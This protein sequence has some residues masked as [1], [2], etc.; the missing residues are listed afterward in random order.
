M[1]VLWY[2]YFVS[3]TAKP[4]DTRRRKT[5]LT[6]LKTQHILEKCIQINARILFFGTG[7]VQARLG[8]ASKHEQ[9]EWARVERSMSRHELRLSAPEDDAC[10]ITKKHTKDRRQAPG[11]RVEA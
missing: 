11:R 1:I 6:I 9:Y 2:L 10:S 4:S 7:V 3:C 5:F 8:R